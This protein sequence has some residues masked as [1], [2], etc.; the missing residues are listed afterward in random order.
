V[1]VRCVDEESEAGKRRCQNKLG[2]I[3]VVC[4]A[5]LWLLA[6]PQGY[7]V[8]A[9]HWNLRTLTITQGSRRFNLVLESDEERSRS[10]YSGS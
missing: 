2:L 5:F 3:R 8:L 6:R 1:K 4:S 10:P 7:I 9:R